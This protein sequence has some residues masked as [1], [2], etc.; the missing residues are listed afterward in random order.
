MEHEYNF[1]RDLLDTYQS[2]PDW[3]KLLWLLIPAAMITAAGSAFARLVKHL[4]SGGNR[5]Q[6]LTARSAYRGSF[7]ADDEQNALALARQAGQVLEATSL[8]ARLRARRP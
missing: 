1:W 4:L 5:R 7:D 6:N 2:L 3:L 8:Y